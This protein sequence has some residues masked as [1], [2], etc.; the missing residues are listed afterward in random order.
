MTFPRISVFFGSLSTVIIS[1]VALIVFGVLIRRHV[2]THGRRP[3]AGTILISNNYLYATASLGY[4]LIL[5]VSAL[6]AA[7]YNEPSFWPFDHQVGDE[8]QRNIYHFSKFYEYIDVLIV[9]ANGGDVGLH[10]AF[11]HLTVRYLL[12]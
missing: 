7:P 12:L 11:H 5:I 9:L 6:S 10:F 1:S 2:G 8:T 3:I 4:C